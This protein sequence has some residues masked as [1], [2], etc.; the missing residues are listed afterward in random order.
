M[1]NGCLLIRTVAAVDVL[2][3]DNVIKVFEP[4]EIASVFY[5]I[6]KQTECYFLMFQLLSLV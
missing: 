4:D 1:R 2:L 5:I 6:L 3:S